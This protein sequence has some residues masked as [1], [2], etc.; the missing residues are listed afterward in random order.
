MKVAILVLS[1][2]WV[3][4]NLLQNTVHL[5]QAV[6]PSDGDN[7]DKPQHNSSEGSDEGILVLSWPCMHEYISLF[8]NTA[9][10]AIFPPGGDN[11]DMSQHKK[12]NE[13]SYTS[14]I[15]NMSTFHP[16]QNTAHQAVFPSNG[17]NHDKPRAQQLWGVWSRYTI[18]LPWPCMSIF[19]S[20]SIQSTKPY[21]LLMVTKMTCHSTRSLMKVYTSTI[22]IMSIFHSFCNTTHQVSPSDG[23]NDA[24]PQLNISKESD[25]G[26]LCTGA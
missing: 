21:S 8:F 14:I 12:S 23:D 20:F 11:D 26:M 1:W 17:D 6:F 2:T 13:G 5:H 22:L 16:L 18:V 3:H 9:H 10:Q 19:H 4:F 7:H 25:D 15:L 24:M